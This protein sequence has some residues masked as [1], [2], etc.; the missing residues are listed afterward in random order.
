MLRFPV[1]I[2]VPLVGLYSSAV[3]EALKG[4]PP[5]TRTI[6]LGSKVA[7]CSWR[8]V[9]RLPVAVQLPLAG[10]YSSALAKVPLTPVP[11]ATNTSPLGN[12]VAV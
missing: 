8:A 10:L 3:G 7:V 2:Q 11:A 12:K 9:L 4:P 5:A 1:N 6:P